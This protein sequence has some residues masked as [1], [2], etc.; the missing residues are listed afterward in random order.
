M[1][2]SDD[3]GAS[4]TLLD[5]V[6]GYPDSTWW[7]EPCFAGSSIVW[8]Q[9]EFDLGSYTGSQILIRF[10]FIDFPDGVESS[11]W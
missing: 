2:V 3:F 1:E 10:H 6:G 11:G 4:W 8:V 5:P 7:G 9:S